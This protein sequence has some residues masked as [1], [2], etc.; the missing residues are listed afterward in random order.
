LNNKFII[1]NTK[2]RE[3]EIFK[4]STVQLSCLA[5][6][7]DGKYIAV[8][9]GTQNFQGN[10]LIFLYDIQKKKLVNKLTFHEKGV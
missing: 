9:E 3:Q 10:S 6:S 7:V 5:A 4:D 2:T 8:A 1:E